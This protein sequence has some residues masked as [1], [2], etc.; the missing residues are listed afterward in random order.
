VNKKR[1]TKPFFIS[2]FRLKGQFFR[3]AEFQKTSKQSATNEM[4]EGNFQYDLSNVF[5]MREI[6]NEV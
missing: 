6:I 5:S 1:N 2:V 4:N 3:L